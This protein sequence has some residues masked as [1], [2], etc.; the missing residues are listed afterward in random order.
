MPLSTAAGCSTQVSTKLRK[1]CYSVA[2]VL[3]KVA[4]NHQSGEVTA[5]VAELGTW[6]LS[7]AGHMM[8]PGMIELASMA[9]LR[10]DVCS[11]PCM[12]QHGYCSAA[13]IC[14]ENSCYTF[15]CFF[16]DTPTSNLDVGLPSKVTS[17]GEDMPN[18]RIERP[19]NYLQRQKANR[20]CIARSG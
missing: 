10:C 19:V 20:V 18:R 17:P 15:P 11:R 4:S 9:Q 14:G 16:C 7:R 12:S 2:L 13:M 6:Y 5:P 3:L 8:L 1:C